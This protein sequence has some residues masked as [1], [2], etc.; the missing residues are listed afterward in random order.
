MSLF[1][2]RV[3]AFGMTTETTAVTETICKC[4]HVLDCIG[5]EKEGAGFRKEKNFFECGRG[6]GLSFERVLKINS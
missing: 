6:C 4:N 5:S 1:W 2:C 3:G